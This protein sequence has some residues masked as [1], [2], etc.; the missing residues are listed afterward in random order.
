[1]VRYVAG[2]AALCCCAVIGSAAPARADSPL[3][4]S[5]A[6][7]VDGSH[8]LHAASCP[9]PAL[10]VATDGPHDTTDSAGDVVTS[11]DPTG[12]AGAWTAWN[13]DAGTADIFGISC[14]SRSLCV[15]ADSAG[16][17]LTSSDPAGGQDKWTSTPVDATNTL[18]SVSCP[19]TS[20]CA[21]VGGAGHVVTSTDPTHGAWSAAV[22]VDGSNT[23]RGLSCPSTSLCVAVDGAGNVVSSTD[24]TGG[25]AQ[26][27]VSS[28]D[29]GHTLR[30]VSCPSTSLCVAVDNVGNVLTST[31][32]TDGTSWVLTNVDSANILFAVSCPSTSLCV[33][34]DVPGNV[35]TTTNPTGGVAAWTVAHISGAARFY[36][37]SCPTLELCVAVDSGGNVATGTVPPPSQPTAAP[38]GLTVAAPGPPLATVASPTAR[39]AVS[40]LA[41]DRRWRLAPAGTTI[42]FTLALPGT[43]R[44][45][46][47]RSVRGRRSGRG[48]V[49]EN[50][51][52]RVARRC[53][54][55]VNAGTLSF[56]ARAGVNWLRFQGRLSRRRWLTPGA[57]A[58]E[59][60]AT[61]RAGHRSATRSARFILLPA[62]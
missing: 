2:L 19:S 39:Q 20:F 47:R 49:T 34:V 3:Q 45:A 22:P 41:I 32:P 25:A 6:T 43:A 23:L 44:L 17:V 1:V 18:R 53:T 29:A 36:G 37:V 33:A 38:S 46:F 28:V 5:G 62:R 52:N 10:C 61:D 4:W 60:T 31:T 56:A 13:V 27:T 59:V 15:A 7:N 58:L 14:P 16:N 50:R 42:R 8:Y 57:Y 30:G 12:A 11:T 40:G 24:P 26:W 35:V 9:S 54:R 51:R 55:L 21:V 48:C